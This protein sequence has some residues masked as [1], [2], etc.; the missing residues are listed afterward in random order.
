MIRRLRRQ[1]AATDMGKLLGRDNHLV[2]GA[3]LDAG[4]TQFG[5]TSYVGGLTSGDRSFAVRRGDRRTRRNSPLP[6]STTSGGLYLADTWRLTPGWRSFIDATF[7]NTFVEAS[8][9][10]PT[11]TATSPCSQAATASHPGPS[12]ES[13]ATTETDK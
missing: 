13:G 12:A 8:T 3:S 11:S 9:N 10:S 7:L 2:V 5:A 6:P 4:R 1:P